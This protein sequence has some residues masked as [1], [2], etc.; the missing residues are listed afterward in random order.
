MIFQSNKLL[1]MNS[2]IGAYKKILLKIQP[3]NLKLNKNLKTKS[4]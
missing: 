3:C 4:I 2:I 1:I